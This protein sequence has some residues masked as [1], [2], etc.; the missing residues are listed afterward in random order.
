MRYSVA[1]TTDVQ[2]Q[3]TRHLVRR[4]GQEDLC[5]GLWYPSRG[6]S[7]FTA[8][9]SELI[10]PMPAERAVHGNASFTP[11]YFDRSM[12]LARERGAGLAFLHSHLG[13][14]WQGMSN[15]DVVA[16]E[17]HAASANG[18]T[19]LPLLGMTIGTD[20]AWSARLWERIGRRQYDRRWCE[21]V[22]LCG[23]YHA[24]TFH[25][26]LMPV[27][28]I[29][30][31]LERT[32]SAWGQKK[33]ADIGR[34]KVGVI[35]TG[36][37]GCI[38]AE[39][40]ARMGFG[41]I[42]LVDFD[43]VE[44][45]NLDRLLHATRWDVGEAKVNVLARGLRRSAT[46]AKFSVE[47]MEYSISEE[48]AFRAALDCDVLFGCVDRPLGRHVLNFIAYAHLIPVVDGGIA[49]RTK[50][51]G[52]VRHCD[53]RAHV[54]SPA[55]RCL[56]CLGQYST[57]LVAAERDGLLDDPKYIEGL[58]ADADIRH[59]EN[60]FGFSAMAA[61]LELMQMLAMVVVPC[62]IGNHGAQIYHFKTGDLDR[63]HASSCDAT[64]FFPRYVARGDS[65][66]VTL[67]N[68]HAAA[69]QARA[70]RRGWRARLRSFGRMIR[71]ATI[72]G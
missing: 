10:P 19:G 64:C 40:L 60:V 37:V 3:A 56:E 59:R 55:R 42:L 5:F 43:E 1:L 2:G 12:S 51:N 45:V 62:G 11:E 71:R 24:V 7:R 35:G 28:Q 61:S 16:E 66:D 25:N 13:P 4:D 29:G 15:D 41:S 6:R 33:Q 52:L 21:S 68:P 57:G 49:I 48:E 39:A 70:S 27:P 63:E 53:M 36:S 22:R 38:V 44:Q 67:T 34:L 17:S 30:R 8:L 26:E 20:G 54:A 23:D 46:A 65:A 18:A 14:G 58:P 9:L 32:V 50:P 31:E 72:W 69:T 47:T